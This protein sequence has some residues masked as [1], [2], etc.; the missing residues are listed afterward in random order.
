MSRGL[1]M[2]VTLRW[3]GRTVIECDKDD[4]DALKLD[5][6]ALGMLSCLL[7]GFDLLRRHPHL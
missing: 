5:T 1:L 6:L 4:V 2:W 7:P 3:P